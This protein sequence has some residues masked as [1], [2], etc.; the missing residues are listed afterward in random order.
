MFGFQAGQ[1]YWGVLTAP[2]TWIATVV[3]LIN[4]I[5]VWIVYDYI[6]PVNDPAYSILQNPGSSKYAAGRLEFINSL[7]SDSWYY[8]SNGY[9]L[10]PQVQ[11]LARY[12]YWDM[13]LY[14]SLA[15][16]IF[17][18]IRSLLIVGIPSVR[19][20]LQK[21]Y[22]VAR[23]VYN[24]IKG[25]GIVKGVS[26][27]VEDVKSVRLKEGT[28]ISEA[29]V[30]FFQGWSDRLRVAFVATFA[31]G[32]L[33]Y[34]LLFAVWALV[35]HIRG[36][37][38]KYKYVDTVVGST[39]VSQVTDDTNP[40][41]FTFYTLIGLNTIP[42][43]FNLFLGNRTFK[44]GLHRL[45]MISVVLGVAINL[46]LSIWLVVMA[47]YTNVPGYVNSIFH[48]LRT[49]CQDPFTNPN[50]GCTNRY[51]CPTLV[52]SSG[53]N[54]EAIFLC[55][56]VGWALITNIA[57][58]L[59]G[60]FVDRAIHTLPYKELAEAESEKASEEAKNVSIPSSTTMKGGIGDESSSDDDHGEADT[61]RVPFF[62]QQ[63]QTSKKTLNP[64]KKK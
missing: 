46:V 18:I 21:T 16:V 61:R 52:P 15:I 3:N 27:T 42:L 39:N 8:N 29:K 51:A 47:S 28:V 4:L 31:L 59:I 32:Q 5:A 19:E 35:F 10:Y 1:K 12:E 17:G 33:F 62:K 34:L 44:G 64:N 41:L 7:T 63:Q 24:N 54:P 45:G 23:D 20:A 58:L 6:I 26:K 2:I 11:K 22:S 55:V 60:L 38:I 9:P 30:S 49:Y 57:H 40:T 56:V 50:N 14:I 48:D 13:H 25:V 53:A 37:T 36:Q 43:I